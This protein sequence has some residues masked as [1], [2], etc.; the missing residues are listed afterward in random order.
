MKS[1]SFE[2]FR[3][4]LIEQRLSLLTNVQIK[5][6]S[7]GTSRDELLDEMDHAISDLAQEMRLR[8]GNREAL[9]LKKIEGAFQR[10][11]EGTYG[12]CL[13]CGAEIGEKRLE[14]RPTAELCIDC[15]EESERNE[16][17]SAE[18]RKPKSVGRSIAELKEEPAVRVK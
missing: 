15:K 12:S 18:G 3:K 2:K 13:A 10:I 8:M 16:N 17:S 14:A 6:A 7:F 5:S 1:S 4:I 9:Y 11:Q